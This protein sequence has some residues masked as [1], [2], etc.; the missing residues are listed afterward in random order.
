MKISKCTGRYFF[1]LVVAMLLMGG[2][3]SAQMLVQ[4]EGVITDEQGAVLPG[5]AVTMKNVDTGNTYGGVSRSDGRY[6]IS[7]ILS[8]T[9]DITAELSGFAPESRKGMNLRV[10]GKFAVDFKLST[11]KV[12][13]QVTVTAETPVVEVTKSEVSGIV[14]RKQ[15]DDLPLLGRNFADLALLKPGVQYRAGSA[16]EPVTANAQPRGSGDFLIDG[17]SN[18][19]V[20]VNMIRSNI[21]PDAIQ[22]FR[23]LTNQFSAELGNSSGLVLNAITRSGTNKLGGRVYGF[24]R[25]EA[26]DAVNYFSSHE[27]YGGAKIPNPEKPPFTDYRVGGYLGGPII[28]DKL[29]FFLSYEHPYHSAYN[30]VISPL[31]PRENVPW[32]SVDNMLLA[33][34]NY[35]LS[36]K[37]LFTLRYSHSKPYTKGTGP[38]GTA[39]ADVAVDLYY[40]DDSFEATWTN[41][42]SDSTLNELRLQYSSFRVPISTKYPD[43]YS[44]QRPSLISGKF[45]NQP[46]DNFE[47]RYQILDN[48]SVFLDKH[49]LKFGFDYNYTDNYGWIY[50]YNPG[51][52]IF[53]TDA[54][55]NEADPATYP[56]LFVYSAGDVNFKYVGVNA[57]L[58]AQDS[59]R[60]S[61]RL[62]L[63]LGVRYSYYKMG[64]L[65]LN[66]AKNFDPRLGF[67]WDPSGDGKSVVRGGFGKFT[68]SIM[69]NQSLLTGWL[70]HLQVQY[71]YFPNYPN[72]T[73]PNPFGTTVVVPDVT[74]YNAEQGQVPPSTTQVTLGYQRQFAADI[75]AGI[76]FVYA[77]GRH[78]LRMRNLNPYVDYVRPDPT[79]GDVFLMEGQ[80]KSDYRA[81]L[82]S[83]SKR[84][85]HGWGMEIAYT[86]SKGLNDTEIEYFSPASEANLA[87]D[88]G[89]NDNDARHRLAVSGMV[90]LPLGL[91]LSGLAYYT[92][93]LP[94]S[95]I[96]GN[97]DYNNATWYAYPA[98]ERRNSAR[99]ADYFSMNVRISKFVNL[100]KAGL[101]FFGEFF[102]VTN[103]NNFGGFQGNMQASDFG[104]PTVAS[105]PRL[106]Q[107]GAR[108]NF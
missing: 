75:S 14:D 82:L 64:D 101:Q 54:P 9:Y 90:D 70:N 1:V 77:K 25:N 88:Y 34:L 21:P 96:T 27:S 108:F 48:F 2:T 16:E 104:K 40:Q 73:V 106:I 32:S 68:N 69:G 3:L 49:Q 103:R 44:E 12:E 41:F 85:S 4:I 98:G 60:I 22:E 28:K 94:Y 87:L 79:K 74:E 29:H 10:G 35:Q 19:D 95:V 17:V 20:G 55:F 50:Q 84:Y 52:I 99:G 37:N 72:P 36:E 105:D 31:V 78:L 63:N 24:Y 7:G 8:G 89:P 102:N 57:G 18:K 59:W 56:F 100:K 83:I 81:L 62:T 80:G 91:Q 43:A 13:E 45:A 30:V 6:V 38:G 47:Y 33:K 5:A 58:Y 46:Q 65:D 39:S 26:F 97:D 93:A 107:L 86:L 15:I 92:S 76:D 61:S 67:S 23:V 53:N 71:V 51:I 66:N 11:K 42:P